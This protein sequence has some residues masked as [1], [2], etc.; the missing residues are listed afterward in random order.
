MIIVIVDEIIFARRF[1]SRKRSEY[2]WRLLWGAFGEVTAV[3][4]EYRDIR[5]IHQPMTNG[6][7]DRSKC[8]RRCE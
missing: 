6:H 8:R 5:T 4:A 1:V 2:R 3:A 7:L